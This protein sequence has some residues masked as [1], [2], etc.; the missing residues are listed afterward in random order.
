[1]RGMAIFRLKPGMTG[2]TGFDW[3]ETRQT[4]STENPSGFNRLLARLAA[5]S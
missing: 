4:H 3:F 2:L 1:M 5:N